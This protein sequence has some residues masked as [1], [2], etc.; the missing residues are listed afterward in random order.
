MAIVERA[1]CALE[2]GERVAERGCIRVRYQVA[3]T[4]TAALHLETPPHTTAFTPGSEPWEG[5]EVQRSWV[6]KQRYV[7]S[8]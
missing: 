1:A 8:L 2:D 3:P 5:G 6:F 7:R 4:T